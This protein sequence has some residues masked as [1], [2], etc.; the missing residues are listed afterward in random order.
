MAKI[1]H[2]FYNQNDLLLLPPSLG[3]LIPATHPVRIVNGIL[4][5]VSHKIA[6][7]IQRI[8]C[9]SNKYFVS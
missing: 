7:E 2:K 8:D 6:Q 5:R 1:I 9:Q 4:D 3:E